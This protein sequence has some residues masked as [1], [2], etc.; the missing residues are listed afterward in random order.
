[1]SRW[2]PRQLLSIDVF[3]PQVS[4]QSVNQGRGV[5]NVRLLSDEV[6]DVSGVDPASKSGATDLGSDTQI[7]GTP[8]RR[9]AGDTQ[10][11]AIQSLPVDGIR[12][13]AGTVV[14]GHYIVV[15]NEGAGPPGQAA[16]EIGRQFGLVVDSIYEA[17]L[18]GFAAQVPVGQLKALAADPR[19]RYV[20]Q[21]RYVTDAVYS[22]GPDRVNAEINRTFTSA[23][24]GVD[25]ATGIA[26]GLDNINV[27]VID[28]GIDRNNS[29][30]R[31]L[32]GVSYIPGKTY[33]DDNGHGTGV[34]SL[35]G[36]KAD[37]SGVAD[38]GITGVAPGISLYAVK[39]LNRRGSGTWSQ[40]I[41]GVDWVAAN[42][43]QFAN[44]SLSG[45][46]YSQS[47][48][49]AIAGA[50]AKGVTFLVAAGNSAVD[51]ATTSPGGF[52]DTVI[53]VSALAD[54]DGQP[55]GLGS[56]TSYGVDDTL[57][58]FSNYGSVVDVVAPGVAITMDKL[59]GGTWV[60]SG[61]SMATPIATGVAALIVAA[62]RRLP[63]L[64]AGFDSQALGGRWSYIK[65][66]L[67]ET[68]TGPTAYVTT[69]AG[70]LV[71]NGGSNVSPDGTW[72]NDPDG[73]AEPLVSAA[74]AYSIG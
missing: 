41:N 57:A 4:L 73:V 25:P 51:A 52:D 69:D 15:L 55:G 38:Q 71:Q 3:P 61:T 23:G 21:D 26:N 16:R 24:V 63:G 56:R 28:T 40:V 70:Q 54:S 32:G 11:L 36:A 20:E 29:D 12:P 27:A 35:I 17:A 74:T 49:D 7:I 18:H 14:P 6:R 42:N 72:G 2:E 65:E 9:G 44:M 67:R 1:M 60:A 66:R 48:H 45:G 22:T 46:G 31:V 30:L 37:R 53:T 58:T 59:G 47:L 62:D 5:V 34:A 43:I 13:A 64:T 8:G 10:G 68:G 39:V 33:Q 50:T 19:V